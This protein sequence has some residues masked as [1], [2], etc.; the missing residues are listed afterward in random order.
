MATPTVSGL[1]WFVARPEGVEDVQALAG[2]RKPP[3]AACGNFGQSLAE[4]LEKLGCPRRAVRSASRLED[5][6]GIDCRAPEIIEYY[7]SIGEQAAKFKK[8][9]QRIDRG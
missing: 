9:P 6:I 2:G 3:P 4:G 5:A 1:G 7:I 8:V